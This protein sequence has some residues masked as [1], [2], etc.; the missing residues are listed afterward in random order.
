MVD[1][2]S[3][4]REVTLNGEVVRSIPTVRSYNA[5]LALVPGVVTSVNDTVTGPAQTSFPIHGGRQSEGRL[6]LD[7]LTVGS[8]GV[9]NSATNYVVDTGHAQEVTFLTGGALAEVETAGLVMNIVPKSGGNTMHGSFFASGTGGKL[10]SDNLTPALK[11]QGVSSGDSAH[12][13]LRLLRHARRPDPEGPRVVLRERAHRRE[14]EGQSERLLQLERRRSGQVA[15]CAGLQPAG[16]LRPDVR[17]CQR[18]GHVAGD[19]A[20]QNRRLLGRAGHLQ[21]L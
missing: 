12:Q 7:G 19:A 1:V 6:L 10:Q 3:A 13:C 8:P 14:H 20:Q 5:L 18:S 2:H 15:V 16:V 21:N 11:E 4:K 17:E 9:G